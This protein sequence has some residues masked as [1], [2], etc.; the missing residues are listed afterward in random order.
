VCG[1]GPSSTVGEECRATEDAVVEALAP[2]V[3]E[4]VARAVDAGV[5]ARAMLVYAH[6]VGALLKVVELTSARM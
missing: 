5:P 3:E 2:E 1:V 6:P 4:A